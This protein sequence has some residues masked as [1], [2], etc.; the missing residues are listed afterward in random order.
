MIHHLI[1]SRM[2]AFHKHGVVIHIRMKTTMVHHWT[3]SRMVV[4]RRGCDCCVVALDGLPSRLEA[5]LPHISRYCRMVDAVVKAVVDFGL[6]GPHE[7]IVD[8]TNRLFRTAPGLR[9]LY[10]YLYR[11]LSF[12]SSSSSSSRCSS[13]RCSSCSCSSLYWTSMS[14]CRVNHNRHR[15]TRQASH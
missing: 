13:S 9:C 4:T 7:D 8:S 12:C 1:F 15:M 11:H 10:R 14:S 5:V 2:V 3:F 6:S